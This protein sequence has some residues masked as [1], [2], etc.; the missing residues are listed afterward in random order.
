MGFCLGARGAAG[1]SRVVVGTLVNVAAIVAG[2]VVGLSVKRELAPRHQ[3][4]I[5]TILGVLA[6]YAGFRMVWMSMGG[7]VPRMILQGLLALAALVLGNLVGKSLGLQRRVNEL[8]RGA[9]EKFAAASASGRRNFGE[10][11]VT[12]SILFCVGPM[13]ILGALQD[14][15]QGDPRTLM[16][17]AMMDGLAMVAFVK[18]FGPGSI[19]AAL[20][21]LA[22]QGTITLL[23]AWLG[24]ATKNPGMVD[25]IGVTGGLL[26]AMTSLLILEV[27]KVRLADYLPA[28]VFA[29]LF[30]IL[31]P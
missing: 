28:L 24:M 1:F 17:K 3:L 23:S 9:R 11:F 18:V 25:G 15:L 29:P 16:I 12:C 31:V 4:F 22:Y 7:G 26:V 10:G 20:P 30:R 2:G 19:L 8:G 27:K 5:K 13:A 14:G 21:V 6:L